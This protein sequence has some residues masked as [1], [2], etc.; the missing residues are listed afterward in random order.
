MRN[1][2]DKEVKLVNRTTGEEVKV[3]DIVTD[4]RGET[5]TVRYMNP[6]HK[7][8]ASGYVNDYYAGV[9]NCKFVEV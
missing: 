4:F 3:G 5:A 6:P 7:S 2:R 1:Y 8:S 9:Y